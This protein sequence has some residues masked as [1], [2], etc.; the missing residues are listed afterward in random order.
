Q[1]NPDGAAGCR[2]ERGFREEVGGDL[3]SAGT[4][5]PTDSDLARPL[6]NGRQHDVHDADPA[7]DEA[8]AGHG[9]GDDIEDSLRSFPLAQ[10]LSGNEDVDVGATRSSENV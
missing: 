6:R 3:G 4:D 1:N 9:S 5:S 10:D 2:E 8:D 7:H